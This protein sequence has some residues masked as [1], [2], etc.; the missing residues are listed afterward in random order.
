MNILNFHKTKDGIIIKKISRNKTHWILKSYVIFCSYGNKFMW[1]LI[2]LKKIGYC[3]RVEVPGR[4]LSFLVFWTARETWAWTGI[5]LCRDDTYS[6]F[7]PWAVSH[8]GLRL[9]SCWSEQFAAQSRCWNEW[10][11]TPY[12]S[13]CHPKPLKKD[14]FVNYHLGRESFPKLF[15]IVMNAQHSP[16]DDPN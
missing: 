15:I 2:T 11:R 5:K 8:P 9:P 4:S 7:S 6:G 3:L 14:H 16:W 1:W 13:R 10:T 12:C